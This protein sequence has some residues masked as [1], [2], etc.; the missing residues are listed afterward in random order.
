M[1]NPNQQAPFWLDREPVYFPPTSLAMKEP[2][3][4]LAIGG[5]LSTEWL[6][7]AYSVGLFPWFNPGEPIL[8]WSPNPR[9]VLAIDQLKIHKSLWKKIKQKNQDKTFKITL[10]HSFT[11]VMQNCSNISRTGQQGTWISDEMLFSYQKL[12]QQGHAHSVEVWQDEQ[13]VGGLYGVAIG[14]MF[15][16]ES[17]FAK[18]SD[19]SKI[20]LVAL[21][22]QLK[23]WGFTHLDAQVETQH[24]NRLGAQN[25]SRQNF[26]KI[27][28]K[29]INQSLN[30]KTWQITDDW[31]EL[32]QQHYQT[33]GHAKPN[34]PNQ[35]SLKN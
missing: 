14:K 1:I 9:S 3:G 20:A 13:L 11:E 5:D 15:F 4:L 29:Q 16:G 6:L 2:N 19:A 10:D 23:R 17:M 25:L 8:W 12:H 33:Q 26:E 18:Q 30:L 28:Q 32:A 35:N 24:L 31:F 7:H 34:K 27:L 22:M 21:A